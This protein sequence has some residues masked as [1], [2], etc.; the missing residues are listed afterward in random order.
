MPKLAIYAVEEKENV[1]LL[2]LFHKL[3]K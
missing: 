2:P 3:I 1:R